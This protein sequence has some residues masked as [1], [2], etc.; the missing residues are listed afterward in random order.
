MSSSRSSRPESHSRRLRLTASAP[1]C[2]RI[3]PRIA[4][5]PRP[6]T[7]RDS[8][9]IISPVRSGPVRT[10]DPVEHRAGCNRP[11]VPPVWLF[12][13]ICW[14]REAGGR[15]AS[16][17]GSCCGR[18]PCMSWMF[19]PAGNGGSRR[20]LTRPG[21]AGTSEAAVVTI[22]RYEAEPRVHLDTDRPANTGHSLPWPRVTAH[23]QTGKRAGQTLKSSSLLSSAE[24][25]R[26]NAG[27]SR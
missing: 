14:C 10:G 18:S 20:S 7:A 4:F 2:A 21:A 1:G 13:V 11:Y 16:G 15:P 12:G 6:R 24:L 8:C 9:L 26:T 25:T 17:A 3:A 22:T 5:V 23:Q 27:W 19:R